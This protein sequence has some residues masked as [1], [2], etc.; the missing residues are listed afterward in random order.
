MQVIEDKSI[1]R[2]YSF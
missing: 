2:Q 1:L